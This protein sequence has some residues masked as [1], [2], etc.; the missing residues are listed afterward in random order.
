DSRINYISK[1]EVSTYK[2][3]YI[4]DLVFSNIPF[5][6]IFIN[7]NL[8]MSSDYTTFITIISGYSDIL[9]L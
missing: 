2:Y 5:T 6:Y 3:R 8:R 7:Y 1:L 9:P 4:I